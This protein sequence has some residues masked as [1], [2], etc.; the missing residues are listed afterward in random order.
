MD[1]GTLRAERAE[2][3]VEFAEQKLGVVIRPNVITPAYRAALRAEMKLKEDAGTSP[4]VI[5]AETI[6]RNLCDLIIEWDLAESS[7]PVTFSRAT[8]ESLPED[9]VT[10]IWYAIDDFL[11]KRGAGRPSK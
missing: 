5:Y 3:V 4:E 7:V 6:L 2:I 10:A 11:G 8:L 9:L 1:L